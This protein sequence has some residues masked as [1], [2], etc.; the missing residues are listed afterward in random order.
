MKRSNIVLI[1]LFALILIVTVGS[2]LILK[3]EYEKMDK[4]NPLASYTK[5]TLPA[6]RYLKLDGKAFAVTQIQPGKNHELRVIAEPQYLKWK[7]EGDTLH[8]TYLRDWQ[9]NDMPKEFELRATPT[10]Y[11]MAP[12]LDGIVSD[13]V[14]LKVNNWDIKKMS[15]QL[16]GGAIQFSENKIEDLKLN[17]NGDV[18][19]KIDEKNSFGNASFYV[20]DHS[21]LNIDNDV[22]QSFEMQVDSSAHI[23]LPG[24][25][26]K[27][28][29]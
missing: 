18:L 28:F 22:F 13:G 24:S 20:Y 29:P 3:A 6:F 16:N 2:N 4:T 5:V 19:S 27:K 10:F 15:V 9:K 1:G 8:F 12:S 17:L 14:V 21:T 26:L 11:I 25:L 7:L 23:S